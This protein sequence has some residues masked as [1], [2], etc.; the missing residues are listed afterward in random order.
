MILLVSQHKTDDFW[1]DKFFFVDKF[2]DCLQNQIATI[3]LRRYKL[4]WLLMS[5]CRTSVS[6]TAR[7]LTHILWEKVV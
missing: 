2:V 3:T 6:A 7:L 5:N 4:D 1:P